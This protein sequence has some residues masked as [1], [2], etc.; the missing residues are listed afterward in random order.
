VAPPLPGEHTREV[1]AGWQ[2]PGAA[3]LLAKGVAVQA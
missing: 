3:D 2:V 1:L